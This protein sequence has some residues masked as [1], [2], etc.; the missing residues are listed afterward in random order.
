MYFPNK[1]FSSRPKPF[2]S[3][4]HPIKISSYDCRFLSSDTI[5]YTLLINKRNLPE[6]KEFIHYKDNMYFTSTIHLKTPNIETPTTNAILSF[7]CPKQAEIILHDLDFNIPKSNNEINKINPNRY[8]PHVDIVSLSVKELSYH[9]SIFKI[10][11]IVILD[12]HCDLEEK[13][14]QFSIFYTSKYLEDPKYIS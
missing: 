10:P 5:V 3:P 1:S 14:T 9:A 6:K 12:A 8:Y 11:M 7:T 13:I 4:K 2:L